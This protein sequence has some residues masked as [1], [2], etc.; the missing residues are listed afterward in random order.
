MFSTH[1][2]MFELV[3]TSL[4]EFGQSPVAITEAF[5]GGHTLSLFMGVWLAITR[6]SG[7]ACEELDWFACAMRQFC[8]ALDTLSDISSSKNMLAIVSGCATSTCV[9]SLCQSSMSLENG[10]VACKLLVS[11]SASF[12]GI[13]FS[14][15]FQLIFV[16][17]I[18][19]S[20]THLNFSLT[21]HSL[22]P[23]HELEQQLTK[24]EAWI[25]L[26]LIF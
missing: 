2:L 13:E 26:P 5:R 3:A 10:L 4:F 24:F 16:R 6:L 15:S 1:L 9:L 12:D 17:L 21:F 25:T 14:H 20:F 23:L 22:L 11:Q 7:D 8:S 19:C 18:F